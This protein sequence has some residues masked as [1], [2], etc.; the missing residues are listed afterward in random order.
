[1]I[2]LIA[3]ALVAGCAFGSVISSGSEAAELVMETLVTDYQNREIRSLDHILLEGDLL[4]AWSY[5]GVF[6]P[7]DSYLVLV[8]D[9]PLANWTHPCRWVFV[10]PD[11]RMEVMLSSIP[12]DVYPRMNVEYTSLPDPGCG[13]GQYE[14]FIE[15]FEPNVQST[16]ENAANMYA[17]I[18]SG[19]ANMGNNHIRYYGDVQ[20]IY[21]VLAHD[22]LLPDDHIIVC[23][24]DGLNPAP[25]QSG[26]L[27]SNP[28]STT[29][30]TATSSM[31]QPPQA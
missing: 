23:F 31:T 14:D 19:G 15:W 13:R 7:F 17:W 11:G 21:N 28:T 9:F 5:P 8:D 22:Y 3:L 25:D 1:M 16:P 6:V 30:A 29:T 18:I 26:G 4:G 12:P 10:S 24:A 2:K 27:N 20:F